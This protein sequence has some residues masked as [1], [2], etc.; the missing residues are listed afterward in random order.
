MFQMAISVTIIST[1]TR[2]TLGF[3]L[4]RALNRNKKTVKKNRTPTP[5]P[6]IAQPIQAS[7]I[8]PYCKGGS[9][10]ENVI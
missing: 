2:L 9:S 7:L 5:N 1:K 10:I 4:N 6:I 3:S 8:C